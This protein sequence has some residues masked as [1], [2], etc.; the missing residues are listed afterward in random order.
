MVQQQ[1]MDHSYA[2]LIISGSLERQQKYPVLA[3]I[4]QAIDSFQE[5]SCNYFSGMVLSDDPV[6]NRFFLKTSG[7]SSDVLS[8]ICEI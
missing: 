8:S 7:F 2:S 1:K 5:N 3:D 4:F 6:G